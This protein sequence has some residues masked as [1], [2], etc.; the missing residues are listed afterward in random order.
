MRA[1]EPTPSAPA[2]T[3][4]IRAAATGTGVTAH[5]LRYYERIGLVLPVGRASSGHR[6]YTEEDLRWVSFLRKLHATGMPI[7]QM[8]EYARFAR[9]GEAGATGRRA[10]LVA[11]RVEVVAR[12]EQLQGMLGTIDHK[13]SQY[14]VPAAEPSRRKPARAAVSPHRSRT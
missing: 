2:R 3:V 5:T 14:D 9:Q 8:L 6:R 12:L 1:G 13:L 7:R 10:L 4:T 11:H